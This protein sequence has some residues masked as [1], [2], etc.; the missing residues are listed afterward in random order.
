M[1]DTNDLVEGRTYYWINLGF[2][3]GS[4]FRFYGSTTDGVK[5]VILKK[6]GTSSYRLLDKKGN[7]V[8][9]TY[10]GRDIFLDKDDAIEAWNAR[11]MEEL[12]RLMAFKERKEKAIKALL[13]N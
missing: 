6:D 10:T 5:E 13:I 9:Y 3:G 8:G 12:D 2:S 11:V 7:Y 1:V 4:S